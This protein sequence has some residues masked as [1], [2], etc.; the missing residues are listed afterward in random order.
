MTIADEGLQGDDLS[1]PHTRSALS[2]LSKF[3]SIDG[4]PTCTHVV[5]GIMKAA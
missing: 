4:K 1:S 3:L 5:E 2:P